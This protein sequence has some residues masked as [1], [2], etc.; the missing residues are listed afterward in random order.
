MSATARAMMVLHDDDPIGRRVVRFLERAGVPVVRPSSSDTAA[1]GLAAAAFGCRA[2][3]A[4]GDRFAASPAV[5]GA[6]NMPGVRALV[7]VVRGDVNL[8]PLKTRGV[9]Y[10]VLRVAPLLDDVVA[11]LR[12]EIETGR[13]I[14]DPR[15]DPSVVP[16]SAI[17][18]AR[19]AIAA[20]DDD[21]SCGRVVHVAAPERP[22]LTELARRSARAAGRELKIAQW[23][24]WALAALRA[25]GRRSYRLPPELRARDFPTDDLISL[26]REPWRTVEEIAADAISSD[27]AASRR[28]DDHALEMSECGACVER[29][30]PP[31]KCRS[32][33]ATSVVF[34]AAD[35]ADE[36]TDAP[37]SMFESW[38]RH[39]MRTSGHWR[40][41]A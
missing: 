24:R 30:R 27:A 19:C 32:C 34:V 5:L 25:I 13:L 41:H 38:V 17:D 6:A 37:E 16:V 26:H 20:V 2:I 35:D 4:V 14:I 36:H 22:T 40:A 23:P 9:P 8:K 18:A 28:N 1:D 31:S 33:E 15:E 11:A 3:I 39:G 21:E 10:T 7:V 29:P 12:P